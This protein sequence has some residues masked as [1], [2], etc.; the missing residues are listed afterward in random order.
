MRTCGRGRRRLPSNRTLSLALTRSYSYVFIRGSSPVIMLSEVQAVFRPWK[1]QKRGLRANLALHLG[2]AH[3]HP[4]C[5]N[6]Q[7]HPCL[8]PNHHYFKLVAGYLAFTLISFQPFLAIRYKLWARLQR[9]S[10]D[11]AKSTKTKI[12]K[13]H[14]SACLATAE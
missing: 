4:S 12:T 11:N 6:R 14:H 2:Q 13:C 1:L 10:I 7:Q 9:N 8:V 5:S 3:A